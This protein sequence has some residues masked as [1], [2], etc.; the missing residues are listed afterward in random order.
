MQID[1]STLDR[2]N[3]RTIDPRQRQHELAQTL[4][5][6][7]PEYADLAKIEQRAMRVVG[8][9]KN[10]PPERWMTTITLEGS[11]HG[12]GYITIMDTDDGQGGRKL[13]MDAHSRVE[14]P[15]T[16]KPRRWTRKDL[17]TAASN[18][19]TALAQAVTMI[20]A[21]QYRQNRKE[22]LA[23]IIAETGAKPH[24]TKTIA[25]PW[26]IETWTD[27]TGTL[28]VRIET[29]FDASIGHDQDL[30]AKWL[31]AL[32]TGQIRIARTNTEE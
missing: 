25:E 12:E 10:A 14:R 23:R 4:L 3:D 6:L 18:A 16:K 17:E 5:A 2:I 1:K 32:Q 20:S 11:E 29:Q 13:R 30:I 8:M 15:K 28:H 22:D 26:L 31:P 7:L 19:A 21:R 27:V 24:D 9:A